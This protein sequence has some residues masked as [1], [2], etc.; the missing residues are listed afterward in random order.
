MQISETLLCTH[1]QCCTASLT[2]V[3][4]HTFGFL[5]SRGKMTRLLLYAL[6]RATLVWRQTEKSKA[7][8][9]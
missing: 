3:P 5:G 9:R 8:M 6:R 4:Q 2:T 7:Q 1:T